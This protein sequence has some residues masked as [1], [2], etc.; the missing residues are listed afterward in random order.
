C[1]ER[2]EINGLII[3]VKEIMTESKG[4]GVIRNKTKQP[5]LRE[6]VLDIKSSVSNLTSRFDGL[7][8]RFDNIVA[9]NNLKE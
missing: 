9:K 7:E 3:K 2:P 1:E 5:S 8:K 4:R 6:I